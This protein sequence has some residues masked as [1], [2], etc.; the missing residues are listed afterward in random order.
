MKQE[1]VSER[2]ILERKQVISLDTTSLKVDWWAV[3]NNIDFSV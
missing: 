1:Q 3:I 2:Y